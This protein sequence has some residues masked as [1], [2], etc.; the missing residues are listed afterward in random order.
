MNWPKKR[1]E[2]LGGIGSILT[3]FLCTV[4]GF[5]DFRE[6]ESGYRI[7]FVMFAVLVLNGFA[8]LRHA[9]KRPADTVPLVPSPLRDVLKVRP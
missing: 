1:L 4:I 8:M 5:T 7:W 9:A 2:T 6:Q 3:G